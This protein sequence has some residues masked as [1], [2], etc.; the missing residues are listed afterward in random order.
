M[1]TIWMELYILSVIQ[2]RVRYVFN[3]LTNKKC[4]LYRLI[5]ETL[6]LFMM[7]KNLN[8]LINKIEQLFFIKDQNL[9]IWIMFFCYKNIKLIYCLKEITKVF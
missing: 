3:F 2:L 8:L 4:I 5:L 9:N 6:Q 7:L 1:Q